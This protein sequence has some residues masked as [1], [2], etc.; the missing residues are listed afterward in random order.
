MNFTELIS[1]RLH[2]HYL[3]RPILKTPEDVVQHFGAIQA[4][5]YAAATWSIG[6]RM[7]QVTDTTIQD[8]YNNGTILRTH[9]MRPT[10]HFVLP[11]N[12][13]WMQ[14]LT[15]S[16]VKK[17]LGHY[18]RK[19]ELTDDLLAKTNM[20]ITKALAN[21]NYLTRKELKALLTEQG[22]MT[23]VQRLG[24]I[25][26]KAELDGLIC[27][28]PMQGKPASTRKSSST[29]GGQFTYA[30]LEERVPKTKSLTREESLAKLARIYI[31][32]HGPI[33]VK[34]FSWWS[35]LSL[36]DATIAIDFIQKDLTKETIDAKT[37]W[38]V[39][40]KHIVT[41]PSPTAYLLSIFDEYAIAYRDRSAFSAERYVEQFIS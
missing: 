25:V 8:A 33:Q 13:R 3:S 34:D 4:Q 19:L 16:Q 11:E 18:N 28:G 20:I 2:N 38:Y 1:L 36:K 32:S 5:D 22:I 35:G 23:D 10:W 6:L 9:I 39:P 14:E 40:A 31:Q 27:S 17:L 29:Q 41:Q 30:L 15:A 37:Y 7:Q 12:I 26:M 24:H 21:N